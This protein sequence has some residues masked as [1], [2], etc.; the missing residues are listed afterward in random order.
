M[1]N[2]LYEKPQLVTFVTSHN[3]YY[4]NG[5]DTYYNIKRHNMADKGK[6]ATVEVYAI[7]EI[8]HIIYK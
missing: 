8:S 2:C 4:Q 3:D 1:Q 7:L 5:K 6:N